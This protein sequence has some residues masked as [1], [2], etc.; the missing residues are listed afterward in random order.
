MPSSAATMRP[1]TRPSSKALPRFRSA[2]DLDQHSLQ[3]GHIESAKTVTQH[4]IAEGAR[5]PDPLLQGGLSQIGFQL[6]KARQAEDEAI[7]GGQEDGLGRDVG[8]LAGI[9]QSGAG[10]AEVEDLM[11]VAGKR[12]EVVGGSILL[13]HK[14]KKRRQLLP[15][16]P[17]PAPLLLSPP[18]ALPPQQLAIDVGDLLQVVLQLVVVL[19]PAA[20][21][22]QVFLS[23]DAA[24]RATPAQSDGQ[25]PHRA[26]PLTAS[27]L[28]RR[29][30]TSHITLDQGSPQNLG[31]RRN[32]LGQSLPATAQRQF[33]ETT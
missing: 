4:I 33:G 11:K 10:G 27:T 26:M 1:C 32:Q 12:G 24:R 7:E 28:A 16:P 20:H 31:E 13:F 17:G 14:S 30:A 15:L 25:I 2:I 18:L 29:V 23:D 3:A 6:L 22:G 21:L 19:D 9:E 8:V 5:A